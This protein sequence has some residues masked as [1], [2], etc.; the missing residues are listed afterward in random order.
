MKRS[1]Q[2]QHPN[3]ST[4]DFH[5]EG[6]D[7]WLQLEMKRTISKCAILGAGIGGLTL[8]LALTRRGFDATVYE[9]APVISEI[10]AGLL[11][12]PNAVSIL[13]ALGL[14]DGLAGISVSTPL[15]QVLNTKGKA[16][17]QIR[18]EIRHIPGI[19]LRRAD[20]QQLLVSHLGSNALSLGHEAV[21]ISTS[22]DGQP[23][24]DFENTKSA[25]SELVVVAEGINS[26]AR[27]VFF[28]D[29]IKIPS[30]YVG[31][32]AMVD[33]V[34]KGW[35][36]G[37]VTETW[38]RGMRFGIAATGSGRCYWYASA[39]RGP[40]QATSIEERKTLLLRLF[41]EW[42]HPVVDVLAATPG[43][44][45]LENIIA[46]RPVPNDWH[47]DGVVLLGDAAH[48][49]TPNLGQGAAMAIEDAWELSECLASQSNLAGALSCYGQRRRRRVQMVQWVSRLVGLAIQTES[50]LLSACRDVLVLATP[51]FLAQASL[52][53]IFNPRVYP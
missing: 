6:N 41:A 8:A 1:S 46:E 17:S 14:K 28:K 42:H 36:A 11:L 50:P 20:L 24:V 26:Q 2:F 48:A 31:W 35:E 51:S 22:G 19:S 10:G 32:R 21:G 18:P 53:W 40:D 29:T 49:M 13:Y 37:T 5:S 4:F 9:R 27:N 52:R 25:T 3:P 23:T 39:N 30:Q 15:W 12:S 7:H 47:K 44:Q 16:L 38:G 43:D 34:P 45:I 33:F